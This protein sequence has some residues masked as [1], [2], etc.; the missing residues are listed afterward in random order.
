MCIEDW[1]DCPICL[2]RYPNS[3][4][5]HL[6]GKKHCRNL[7]KF[8]RRRGD[9][10]AKIAV[11]WWTLPDGSSIGLDHRAGTV[12]TRSLRMRS[13]TRSRWTTTRNRS[14]RIAL[15]RWARKRALRKWI[16]E[17]DGGQGA[18]L[19]YL[20]AIQYEFDGDFHQLK[21]ARLEESE[22]TTQGLLGRVDR[23]VFEALGMHKLG[24]KFLLVRGICALP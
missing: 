7:L 22:T 12:H 10:D 20:D 19:Q 15:S 11:Q 3:F 4:A 8:K 24:H 21:C 14:S 18:M 16:L 6:L 17:L 1:G 23:R 9:E 5:G 2:K 13:R